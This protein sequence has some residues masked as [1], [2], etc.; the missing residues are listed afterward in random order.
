M[1]PT[2]FLGW[3]AASLVL[4]TFCARRITSLRALAIV[5]NLAFISYG[6]CDHLWPIVILHTTMLPINIFRLRQ[7]LSPVSAEGQPRLAPPT[8]GAPS[9]GCCRWE[10]ADDAFD[11]S[12]TRKSGSKYSRRGAR[13][14]GPAIEAERLLSPA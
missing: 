5:S 3:F 10:E 14:V 6:Y 7:A 12:I 4:A 2:E 1:T 13:T 9:F 11:V 8:S